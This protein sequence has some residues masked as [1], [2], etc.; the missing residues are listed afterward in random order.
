MYGDL[1]CFT[2]CT[3]LIQI[4]ITVGERGCNTPMYMYMYVCDMLLPVCKST[5]TLTSSISDK[6]FFITEHNLPLSSMSTWREN[7]IYHCSMSTWR[8]GL[9][10]LWW[11][12][13]TAR[14]PASHGHQWRSPK[15]FS[16][17]S[18]WRTLLYAIVRHIILYEKCMYVC[19]AYDIWM[20][21]SMSTCYHPCILLAS[22][23]WG[24][25]SY[26][27]LAFSW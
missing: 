19:H 15:L 25:S 7:I 24:K 3:V 1:C 6:R 11:N 13:Q 27:Y 16:H 4:L 5:A 14:S 17:T 23:S 26:T 10:S 22:R 12:M 8:E 9:S 2:R 18:H 21:L 20:N